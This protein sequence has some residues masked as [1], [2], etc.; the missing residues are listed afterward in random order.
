MIDY[1]YFFKEAIDIQGLT[2]ALYNCEEYYKHLA[3]IVNYNMNNWLSLRDK[4]IIKCITLLYRQN[5]VINVLVYSKYKRTHI[6][7]VVIFDDNSSRV[8][9]LYSNKIVKRYNKFALSI[10]Y[11]DKINVGICS[12]SI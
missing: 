3:S 8:V 7:T 4:I 2:T 11:G 1:Q 9:P 5:G 12:L 10:K 6:N